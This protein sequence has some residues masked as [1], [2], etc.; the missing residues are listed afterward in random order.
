MKAKADIQFERFFSFIVTVVI[1]G[2]A[3]QVKHVDAANPIVRLETNKGAIRI[4]LFEDK[5]PLTVANFLYYVDSG[6]YDGDDG[7]GSTLFHRVEEDFVIQ[8]GGFSTSFYENPIAS[9][10]P[11]LA[12]IPNEAENGLSNQMH[13]I[14]MARTPDPHSA[15]SQFFINLNDN[16]FL[17]H[18]AETPTGW[19]YAV[20][21]KVVAGMETVNAI[22]ATPTTDAYQSFNFENVPVEPVIIS[23][24]NI[25]GVETGESSEHVY[26]PHIAS[27]AGWETEI[28]VINGSDQLPLNGLLRAYDNQG[29]M[30]SGVVSVDLA[31]HGRKEIDIGDAFPNAQS[32]SYVILATDSAHAYGYT[33]FSQ[34][35]RYRVGIPAV[36]DMNTGDIFVPHIASDPSWWTGLSLLN[37]GDTIKEV[38]IEFNNGVKGVIALPP[39]SHHAFTIRDLFKGVPQGEIQSALIKNAEGVIGLE[40][41]GSTEESGK[42]YLTGIL[43]RDDVDF[44]LFF[45]HLVSDQNWW[46]GIVVYNPTS[47]SCRV[48]IKPFGAGGT[49]LATS[50][51]ILEGH[52]KYIGSVGD[53]GLPSEAAWMEVEAENLNDGSECPVTGFELFGTQNGNQ[54]GGYSVVGLDAHSGVFSKLENEGWTGIAIVNTEYSRARVSLVAYSDDGSEIARKELAVNSRSKIVDLPSEIFGKELNSASYIHYISDKKIVGFQLNG[55]ADGMMLDALPAT[56]LY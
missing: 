32:I 17:D 56:A 29:R 11:T 36:R 6:Y 37:T 44:D 23:E 26:F 20:F 40:L 2:W 46:T 12:S 15:A 52:E 22:A 41:F 13:T 53:L 55:S 50:S 47:V 4:E 16:L 27:D 48:D 30:V 14:A 33:K 43:L 7:A 34:E 25:E 35:G 38:R 49:A 51:V 19:G 9:K 54:L 18:T 21:G 3:I 39:K 31:P 1:F 28:C 10:K 45:P 24:A 42:H 8:G 5:A